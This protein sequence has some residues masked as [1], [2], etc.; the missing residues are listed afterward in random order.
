[1]TM[2]LTGNE[3][4]TS[5]SSS[6]RI[7]LFC[8]HFSGTLFEFVPSAGCWLSLMNTLED[9]CR[10]GPEGGAMTNQPVKLGA[11]PQGG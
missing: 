2:L 4:K 5:S 10:G 3:I 7:E 9:Q 8:L 1:M 6:Y 11:V